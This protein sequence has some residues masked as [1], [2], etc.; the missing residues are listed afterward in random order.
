VTRRLAASPGVRAAGMASAIPLM[1]TIGQEQTPL[2]IE[3]APP[4]AGGEAQPTVNFAAITPG[5]LQALGIPLRRGRDI[6]DADHGSAPPVVLVNEAFAKQHFPAGDALGKR[7]ALGRTGVDASPALREIVGVAGDVRR[8]AL[9]EAGQPAVYLPHAQSPTGAN[10]FVL[11]GS[12]PASDLIGLI[13]RTIAELNPAMPAYREATM[14]ELVG[15]SV[16]DRT[17]LLAILGGFAAM[18]L[19][20]AAAGL[21]GLMSYAT[22]ERT[23][24]IG[25]RMAFGADRGQVL[26]LVLRRGTAL[27][28]VGIGL[29]LVGAVVA[30]RLLSGMLYR[31]EPFDLPTF[32]IGAA[33]LL[34]SALLA[35]WYP[36]WRAASIDPVRALHID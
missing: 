28:G 22:A 1:E 11:W 14:A 35:S 29:G 13:R 36:A 33:V 19:G 32:A 7:I 15:A 16:R 25:V 18:A 26:S 3:T 31:V 12:G 5:T 20:L 21:L 30:T 9:S 8:R 6:G 4:L 23:R 17:F 27:A 2:T 24:E 10:A 34:G